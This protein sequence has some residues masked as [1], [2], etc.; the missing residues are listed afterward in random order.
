MSRED[1]PPVSLTQRRYTS[2]IPS[3]RISTFSP[4]EVPIISKKSS[5]SR[6]G[7]ALSVHEMTDPGLID[8]R[9]KS[10]SSLSHTESDMRISLEAEKKE[11]ANLKFLR[12]KFNPGS[13]E[14]ESENVE[15]GHVEQYGQLGRANRQKITVNVFY[16][17]KNVLFQDERA[18]LV[19]KKLF[20]DKE[21]QY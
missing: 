4:T 20:L 13:K 18:P 10:L 16:E 7:N 15:K 11:K 12:Y 17:F 9:L 8:Q 21:K 14:E 19:Y 3:G 6:T 1:L 5:Q 2:S